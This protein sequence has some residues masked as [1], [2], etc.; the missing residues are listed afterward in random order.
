MF[1]SCTS[2]DSAPKKTDISSR[3][4]VVT[5]QEALESSVLVEYGHVTGSGFVVDTFLDEKKNQRCYK[6]ITAAHVLKSEYNDYRFPDPII[7]FTI[8]KERV[9]IIGEIT[10]RHVESDTAIITAWTDNLEQ[11]CLPF[12]IVTDDTYLEY[13][14][15][16]YMIS[17]P[18]GMGPM[19]TEGEISGIKILDWDRNAFTTT[20]QSAP[21]SSGGP[22]IKYDTGEVVGLLKAVVTAPGTPH[23]FGWQS[24]VAPASDIR[25][26]IAWSKEEVGILPLGP[27]GA[28]FEQRIIIFYPK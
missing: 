7:R 5:R 12:R 9:V 11:L 18:Q 27:R 1:A 25:N 2:C 28:D 16:V 8:D 15:D 19:V 21:G 13:F 24:I 14:T 17:Y 3:D 22:V 26:I 4:Y 23:I 6:I 10:Y 20:A